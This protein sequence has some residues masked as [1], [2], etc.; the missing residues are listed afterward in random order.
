MYL[1]WI[2]ILLNKE[3]NIIIPM[4]EANVIWKPI[5]KVFKG[6]RIS[7]IHPAKLTEF[8]T[9]YFLPKILLDIITNAIILALITDDEKLHNKQKTN[10]IKRLII[11]FFKLDAFV[12]EIK[13]APTWRFT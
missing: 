11:N 4:T 3:P 9:S 6:L 5:S 10:N 2:F 1:F 13:T 7:R 12:F 8:N